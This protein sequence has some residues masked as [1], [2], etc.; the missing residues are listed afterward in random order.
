M[1]RSL[2]LYAA[3]W[4]ML[5]SGLVIVTN[6]VFPSPN[7][8]DDEYA[9]WYIA[10]Y[11]ALF[12]LFAIGGAVNSERARPRR[13]GA[14]GG[15]ATA[16]IVIGMVMLTFVVVDNLFLDIVSQ[17]ID[18]ITAFRNQTA[19]TSMRD[20]INAGLLRGALIVLPV[21]AL[22]GGVLGAVASLI[23]SRLTPKVSD[24]LP[25]TSPA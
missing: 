13:S 1:K 19:Y 7:E 18:K 5:L 10:L 24:T 2:L 11:L 14:V 15:A 17:Q 3:A 16:L 25:S 20:F 6:V 8:S 12:L 22:L 23:R 4:G 21:V 9:A